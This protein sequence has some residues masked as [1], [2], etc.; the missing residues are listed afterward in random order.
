MVRLQAEVSQAQ[1][2]SCLYGGFLDISHASP[3]A[4]NG[5]SLF[6]KDLLS[7][8]L[9]VHRANV[10]SALFASEKFLSTHHL[11]ETLH[12]CEVCETDCGHHPQHRGGMQ[13]A[14]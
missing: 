7:A 3:T 11:A 9:S 6:G 13:A 8:W 10:A 12:Y 1:A 2:K 14:G 4:S 5:I